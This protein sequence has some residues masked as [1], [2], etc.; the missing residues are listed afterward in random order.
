M[1][2]AVAVVIEVDS[3]DA[4]MDFDGNPIIFEVYPNVLFCSFIN[5]MNWDSG[6]FYLE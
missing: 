5:F 3:V 6:M 1:V 4:F 2:S